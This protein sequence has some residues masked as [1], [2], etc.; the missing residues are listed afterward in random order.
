M[1]GIKVII[2]GGGKISVFQI[3]ILKTT[4]FQVTICEL[5]S[6]EFGI[7]KIIFSQITFDKFGTGNIQRAKVTKSDQALGK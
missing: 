6:G 4:F 1:T 2:T 5:T 3:G 7:D